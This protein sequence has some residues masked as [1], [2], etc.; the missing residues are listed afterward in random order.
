MRDDRR[1]QY[2]QDIPPWVWGEG[3]YS[4][5]IAQYLL[6]QN[7]VPLSLYQSMVVYSAVNVC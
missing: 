6:I 4:I 2:V 5:K 7:L 1:E 3:A